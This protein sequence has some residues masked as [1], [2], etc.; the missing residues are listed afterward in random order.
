VNITEFN[1]GFGL[2]DIEADYAKQFLGLTS[3]LG[4]G[5]TKNLQIG[6]GSGLSFYNGGMLVPLFL[7]LRYLIS[8]GKI[9]TFAFGDAGL[10]FN[11]SKSDYENKILLNP[12]VGIKYPI[13]SKLSANLCIGLFMQTTKE[14]ERDSFVNFKLGI[15]YSFRK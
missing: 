8:F 10:L 2:G 12:G 1:S 5:I 3:L 4:Y 11:L 6:I 13:G 7:D 9:S 15:T 14:K